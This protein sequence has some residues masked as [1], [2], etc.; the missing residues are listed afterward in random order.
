[1]SKGAHFWAFAGAIL[2]AAILMMLPVRPSQAQAPETGWLVTGFIHDRQ[3]TPVQDAQVSLLGQGDQTP[4]AQAV[5]Q[6]D[7]RYTLVLTEAPASDLTVSIDREHFKEILLPLDQ[8]TVATLRSSGSVVLPEVTLL[9]RVS[10]SFWIAT[11]IF[12]SMLAL[13]ALGK[14]HNTLAALLGAA[15]IF[16]VSYLGRPISQDLFIFDFAGALRYVDWNVIFLIMGMMI[17]IAAVE[18]TG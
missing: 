8:A 5:S 7:G 15:T 16:A 10:L 14:L 17:I 1:M 4:L 18:R 12:V 6:P 11:L 13:I 9:R 2:L 3:G